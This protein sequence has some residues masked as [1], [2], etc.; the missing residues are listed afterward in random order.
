MF[1]LIL[2]AV[3]LGISTA[4][5]VGTAFIENRCEFEVYV[6][7]VANVTN[8]TINYLAPNIGNFDETYRTNPN[9]GGISL[10]IATV[11]VQSNIT[12]FEYTYRTC[13]TN[14]YYDISNVNGGPFQEWG[15][16]LS[17]SAPDCSSV[18]CDPSEPICPDIYYHPRDD[19]AMR[20]CDVSANLTLTLCPSP[21]AVNIASHSYLN[22]TGHCR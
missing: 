11:P 7:S 6:W 5:C 3:V 9:G 13:D 4:N 19:F 14:L 17:P 12:Q 16:K 22:S 15:F 21:R 18:S 8:N 10:K 2:G 20:S 1:L